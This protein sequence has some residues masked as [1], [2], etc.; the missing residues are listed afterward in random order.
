MISDT[1]VM[2]GHYNGCTMN[3][4]SEI[5]GYGRL[6]SIP[7][8][9]KKASQRLKWFA[10][11]KSRNQN[12]RL[13]CRHSGVSP[14]TFYR[15]KRRYDPCHLETLEDRSCRPKRVRQPTYSAELVVASQ[16]LRAF[17]VSTME[18]D[19]RVQIIALARKAC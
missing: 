16:E 18:P 10:Y 3:V 19:K 5:L 15:L 6:T 7:V 17:E 4:Y 11:Y 8:L 12:A 14:Q 2:K 9:S 13:T 1:E